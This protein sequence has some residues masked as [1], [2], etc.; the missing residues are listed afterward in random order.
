VAADAAKVAL[1]VFAAALAQVT[2]FASIELLGGS[3]DVLLVT[4]VAVALLR[5]AITGAAAGFGAGLVVDMANLETLGLTSLVL[6]VAGYWIG[7]YGETSGRAGARAERGAQPAAAT[8]QGLSL[9]A[10]APLL[11]VLVVTALYALGVYALHFMLGD[12]LSARLVLVDALL[13]AILWNLLLT[14]P[15]YALV[16]RLLPP[17][18]VV[19]DR[20]REANLVA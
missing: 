15:V 20:T 17:L 12:D 13:P 1:L 7:R 11:S 8:P 3:P 9:G 5:G 19:V 10:H 4:L 14:V 2:V 18:P 16:R 6:S